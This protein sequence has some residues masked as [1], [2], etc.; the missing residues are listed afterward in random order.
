MDEEKNE[1][2]WKGLLIQKNSDNK[3]QVRKDGDID[4]VDRN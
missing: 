4:S 3:R 2:R 1:K